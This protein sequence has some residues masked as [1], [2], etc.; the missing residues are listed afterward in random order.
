MPK[1]KADNSEPSWV[2]ELSPETVN[3][4]YRIWAV[5]ATIAAL[6]FAIATAILITALI[7]AAN[8]VRRLESE[9]VVEADDESVPGNETSEVSSSGLDGSKLIAQDDLEVD[10]IPDHYIGQKDAKVIV[11][12]Y[13][14]F[15]CSYCQNLARY[16]ERIHNDYRDRV[17]F[18]HRSFNLYFPNSEKTL[19]AAEAAY[20]LGGEKAYWAMSRLLYQD[21][22]WTGDGALSDQSILNNYAEQIGINANK[23]RAAMSDAAVTNKI[24]RDRELGD[25]AGVAGTP[26][27]F[28]NGKQ[29]TPIDSDIR[30]ALDVALAQ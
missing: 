5:S 20:Q 3:K 29:V 22:R 12:E 7:V 30:A 6:V 23:F 13:E 19:S 16:A 27:W 21:T 9:Q 15:A 17:L 11:I 10:E 25:A 1:I 8:D 14:D 2:T 24:V 26:T 28:I 4:R 18:I